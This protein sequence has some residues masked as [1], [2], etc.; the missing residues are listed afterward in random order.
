VS[1]TAMIAAAGG[2]LARGRGTGLEIALV[3]RPRYDDWTLP[4]GKVE[5]GE[6]ELAAAVREVREETGAQVAASRRITR[7]H[8]LVDDVPK[9]VTYWAMRDDGGAFTPGTEVDAMEWL[10]TAKAAQRLTHDTDR[11]VLREFGAL[12]VPDAVVILV[13]HARAGKRREWQG[14]DALRPL[15]PVGRQQA[16]L[17]ADLLACFVPDRIISADPV[18]CVQTVQ[19]LADRLGVPVEVDPVF[20]DATYESERERTHMATQSL[21]ARTGGT[22]VVCSQGITIPALV[23]RLGPGVRHP[24]TRKGA[25]WVLSAVDGEAVAADYYE[26]RPADSQ[27]P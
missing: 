9:T 6:T 8:Y 19:P 3:H 10:P 5:P 13:R 21:L 15:D 2:V 20:S 23:D 22:T 24:D 12:P 26:T 27:Q 4:K 16:E 7:V 11:T 25:A 17:L 1:P 14:D 18:R